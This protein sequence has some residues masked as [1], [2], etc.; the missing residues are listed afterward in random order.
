MSSCGRLRLGWEGAELV[1]FDVGQDRPPELPVAAADLSQWACAQTPEAIHFVHAAHVD[2]DVHAVLDD[3]WL[4]DLVEPDT[5]ALAA[6]WIDHYRLVGGGVGRQ[7][8]K[9]IVEDLSLKPRHRALVR[10]V[11]DDVPEHGSHSL[12]IVA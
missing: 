8:S 6:G 12:P 2:I 1:A 3:L 5:R 9:A 11:E 4:R 7:R 10:A